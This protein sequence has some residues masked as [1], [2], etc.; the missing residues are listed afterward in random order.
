MSQQEF[1][2]LKNL[3]NKIQ[4]LPQNHPDLKKLQ[5]EYVELYFMLYPDTQFIELP[6]PSTNMMDVL[7]RNISFL[8]I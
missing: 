4:F 2:K 5:D 6:N 3:T 1:S 8:K 7:T